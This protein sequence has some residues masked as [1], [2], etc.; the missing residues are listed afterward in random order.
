[1]GATGAQFG[2]ERGQ[3]MVLGQDLRAV[4]ISDKL[5]VRVKMAVQP[6]L[7]HDFTS[8]RVILALCSVPQY[9]ERDKYSLSLGEIQ[10]LPYLFVALIY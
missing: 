6:V 5:Q 10:C 2:S 7:Q 1:M 9:L 4:V 3:L 8:Q